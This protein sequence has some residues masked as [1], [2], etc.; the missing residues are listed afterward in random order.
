MDLRQYFMDKREEE[1]KLKQQFP[2]GVVYVTSKF[3][4]ERNSTAGAVFSATISNAARVITDGTHRVSEE[5]EIR[6]FLDHQEK[7]LRKHAM[8]E[9]GKRQQ[10][11]VITSGVT[12]QE[13]MNSTVVPG[14]R[15]VAVAEEDAED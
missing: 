9:Q 1:A 3:Y 10:Y 13:A 5:P 14:R 12:P 11:M 2:E 4:R 6:S 8:A 7:E 15:G